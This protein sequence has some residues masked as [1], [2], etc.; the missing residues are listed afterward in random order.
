VAGSTA[1]PAD[2]T[3]RNAVGQVVRTLRTEGASDITIDLQGLSPGVYLVEVVSRGAFHHRR[4]L[5][6]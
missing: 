3:L 4:L 1:L 5:V 6:D 2:L